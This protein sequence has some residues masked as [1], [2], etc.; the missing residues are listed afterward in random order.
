MEHESYFANVLM[1][2]ESSIKVRESQAFTPL[3][4]ALIIEYTGDISLSSSMK[5]PETSKFRI[6]EDLDIVL[7]DSFGTNTIYCKSFDVS[8]VD[9]N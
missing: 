8:N 5:L 4:D 3:T 1:E 9:I 2:I 6:N 7:I